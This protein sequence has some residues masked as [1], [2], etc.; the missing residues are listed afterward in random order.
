MRSLNPLQECSPLAS[1]HD[2]IIK[3]TTGCNHHSCLE[4]LELEWK[5]DFDLDGE[6]VGVVK[7]DWMEVNSFPTARP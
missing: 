3:E 2:C 7:L 6:S 1:D 5:N 4:F